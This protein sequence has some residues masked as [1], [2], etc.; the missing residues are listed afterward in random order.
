MY[1]SPSR[2]L[3]SG[4]PG[5]TMLVSNGGSPNSNSRRGRCALPVPR[6]V[7]RICLLRH[8]HDI[9]SSRIVMS[10]LTPVRAGADFVTY[11]HAGYVAALVSAV[12]VIVRYLGACLAF[13]RDCVSDGLLNYSNGRVWKRCAIHCDSDV[14]IYF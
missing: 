5:S 8:F 11:S 10:F 14:L 4:S 6:T 2:R 1:F 7:L 12:A 13:L 3:V 9:R